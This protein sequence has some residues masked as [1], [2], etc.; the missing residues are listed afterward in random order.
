MS[1]KQDE[2][3]SHNYD[4]IQEYDN[5][6]PLWWRWLFYITVVFGGAYI[7]YFHFGP[8]QSQ[9]EIL[10]GELKEVAAQR[11]A[12]SGDVTEE[13]LL[14]VAKK[15]DEVEKGKAIFQTRCVACHGAA[16]QGI[17]GPNLT[18]DFWIHGG[19]LV[20]IRKTIR[21][22]VPAKGMIAWKDS[23]TE[24]EIESV[25]AYIRNIRGTNPAGAKAAEGEAFSPTT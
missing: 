17:V 9:L 5:S 14:A 8:G 18:D 1:K 6:L 11:Q 19:H 24:Q 15:N 3:L 2:L 16:G 21:E 13:Q 10:S 20:E 7:V 12:Q 25:I 22:G 23:M 4:G